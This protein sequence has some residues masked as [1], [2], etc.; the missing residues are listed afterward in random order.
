MMTLRTVLLPLAQQAPDPNDVKPGLIGFLVF[1][2][3]LV[4]VVFLV[5][6]FRKQ[7]R[8]VNFEEKADDQEHADQGNQA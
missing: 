8:K 3:L 6:S 1:L 5:L 4:A 2:A 7:L